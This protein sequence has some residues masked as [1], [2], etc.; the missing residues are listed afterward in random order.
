MKLKYDGIKYIAD[1][2]QCSRQ[3]I[4]IGLKELKKKALLPIG[5]SRVVGG[6]RK[7]C[8]TKVPAVE[9]FFLKCN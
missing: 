8:T 2:L 3:T 9:E 5:K 4:Y 1:L 7:C 6:G